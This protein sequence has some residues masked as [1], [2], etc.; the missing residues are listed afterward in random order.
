M[1][2]LVNFSFKHSLL[3][4]L[5]TYKNIGM[6]LYAM[7]QMILE[8]KLYIIDFYLVKLKNLLLHSN[9]TTHC[10]RSRHFIIN[11]YFFI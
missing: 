1:K 7:H 5:V 9:N 4:A 3:C 10:I 6:L 8:K 11:I 2:N